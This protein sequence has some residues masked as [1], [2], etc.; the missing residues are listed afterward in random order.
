MNIE[1]YEGQSCRLFITLNG[2]FEVYGGTTKSQFNVMKGE[3]YIITIPGQKR[4]LCYDSRFDIFARR[5]S[6]GQEWLVLSGKLTL[7]TRHSAEPADAISCVEYH[8]EKE[9]V[10]SGETVDA[11]VMLIGIKG[12]KGD[13]GERGLQGERGIQ[14]EK[15]IQGVQ[16][17]RGEKGEQG[18][19]GLQ[20]IQG[21]QGE[22]GEKGDTGLSAY[23][24]V[25]Q[26]GYTG[27]E[28]EF[29]DML[30]T[31]ESAADRAVEAQILAETCA[32]NALAYVQ[33]ARAILEEI[34]GVTTS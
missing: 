14:G 28:A 26:H 20:G 19:Q 15:G 21:I 11:G 31:F 22:K 27:T 3:E 4:S 6:T 33:E 25:K 16:G 24:L 2:D 1:L 18:E 10:E 9:L 17:E 7:K 13:T 8:I 34:K 23:E 30:K 32:I 5:K 29:T 12:D